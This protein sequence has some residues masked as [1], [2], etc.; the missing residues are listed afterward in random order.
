[1]RP[2]TPMCRKVCPKGSK[3]EAQK[4]PTN[5]CLLVFLAFGRPWGSKWSQELP[6]ESPGAPQ[7]SIWGPFWKISDRFLIKV[8]MIWF[9]YSCLT[10]LGDLQS[11]CL[12]EY[13]QGIEKQVFGLPSNSPRNR[14]GGGKAAG[15]WI[16]IIY[17]YIYIYIHI[18]LYIYITLGCLLVNVYIY[19]CIYVYKHIAPRAHR[20]HPMCP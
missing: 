18:H 5:R 20:P 19:I 17:I 8:W 4:R 3:M 10:F 14:H 1:M 9:L 7:A 2:E 16:H 6:K 13:H 11:E 15:K 12:C